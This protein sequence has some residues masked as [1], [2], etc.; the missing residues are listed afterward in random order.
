MV[1]MEQFRQV[2]SAPTLVIVPA[3]FK[4]QLQLRVGAL[5]H[6]RGC[7]PAPGT[8]VHHYLLQFTCR[9]S[10][11]SPVSLDR[12]LLGD[13][14]DPLKAKVTFATLYASRPVLVVFLRRLGCPICRVFAKEVESIRECC[15]I[16]HAT[17]V[18]GPYQRRTGPAIESAG[19]SA[20]CISFEHFGEG[21]DAD[22]RVGIAFCACAYSST[23]ESRF[24]PGQVV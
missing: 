23:P 12:T 3:E 18:H 16:L 10:N 9:G 13:A 11:V 1:K 2:L 17:T 21:S 7:A 14:R 4:L 19:C 6:E 15:K 8:R 5:Q 24:P 20:V 22:R